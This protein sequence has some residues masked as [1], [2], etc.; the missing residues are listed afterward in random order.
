M[1]AQLDKLQQRTNEE[2]ENEEEH[3]D[4]DEDMKELGAYMQ[5]LEMFFEKR[6]P[7]DAKPEGDGAERESSIEAEE[8]NDAG[9]AQ[10]LEDKATDEAEVTAVEEGSINQSPQHHQSHYVNHTGAEKTLATPPQH[11]KA[12]HTRLKR[13]RLPAI[14]TASTVPSSKPGTK[15]NQKANA[16][17]NF[18]ALPPTPSTPSTP[19]PRERLVFTCHKRYRQVRALFP[20]ASEPDHPASLRWNDLCNL[21]TAAPLH[22]WLI[23]GHGG[24]GHTVIRPARNGLP[25]RSVVLHKPHGRNSEVERHVLENMGGELAK[26]IGWSKSDFVVFEG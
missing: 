15:S 5:K 3:E 13:W 7:I 19:L 26:H 9:D 4:E 24:A 16:Y 18:P 14:A 21:L 11:P 22:C 25:R 23:P 17:D 12:S 8:D 10:E 6:R 1:Q 20:L 2:K